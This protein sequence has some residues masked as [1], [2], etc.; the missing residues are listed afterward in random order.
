M[1]FYSWCYPWSFL[2][3]LRWASTLDTIVSVG[4]RLGVMECKVLRTETT[5]EWPRHRL[6]LLADKGRV[7]VSL[8]RQTTT[9]RWTLAW[10]LSGTD[11]DQSISFL[12]S[13]SIFLE[14]GQCLAFIQERWPSSQVQLPSVS[15][16]PCISKI[17]EKSVFIRLYNFLNEVGF[18]YHLQS[19][20]RPGD[21]TVM[22]LIYIVDKIVNA[23]LERWNEVRGVLLDISKAF[24]RVWHKG[25]LAKLEK[26]GISD[27]L[28][29]WFESYLWGR[30]QRVV[31]DGQNSEFLSKG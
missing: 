18:F 11:V 16:L 22:Q 31:I 29:R 9:T 17:C 21:S 30:S 6:I 19:G 26:L 24:D 7:T 23:A 1:L 5:Q 8:T 15:L 4:I 25:L 28:Y 27:S 13:V 12:W 14:D 3:S 20:F 2:A 10:L